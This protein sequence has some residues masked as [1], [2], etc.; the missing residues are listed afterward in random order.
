MHKSPVFGHS[1]EFVAHREYTTGHAIRPLAGKCWSKTDRYY[2]KQYGAEPTPRCTLVIDVSES[3]P[4]GGGALNKYESA[5]PA[6]PC[7][8]YLLLR[9]QDAVG[10]ITFD[11]AVRQIVPARSQ[12]THL[13]AVLGAMNVSKPREKTDIEGILRRVT[14]S[15]PGRGMVVILSD[16][17]V[18]REPL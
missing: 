1:I 16:L 5:C 18:G 6:G 14:E 11:S 4:S 7:L 8:S 2:T 17:L 12:M 9:Q 13:D 3:M 15:M 10:C